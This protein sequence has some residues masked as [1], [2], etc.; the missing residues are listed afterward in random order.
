LFRLAVDILDV[1]QAL[2]KRVTAVLVIHGGPASEAERG[3]YGRDESV[4][5]VKHSLVVDADERAACIVCRLPRFYR[6]H[7]VAEFE[8]RM[9]QRPA[10]NIRSPGDHCGPIPESDRFSPPLRHFLNVLVLADVHLA[11]KVIRS[12]RDGLD[13]VRCQ[14][15][16]EIA[17]ARGLRPPPH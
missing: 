2:D 14:D 8:H 11:E 17:R 4:R 12:A 16:L 13:Q 5:I 15:Q 6:F 7:L 10:L 9:G 3:A 1:A